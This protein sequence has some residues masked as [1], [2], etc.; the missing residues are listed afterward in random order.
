MIY[1]DGVDIIFINGILSSLPNF[2]RWGWYVGT[3]NSTYN[4]HGKIFF[5][6]FFCMLQ[7]NINVSRPA[8]PRPV[9]ACCEHPDLWPWFSC[10]P[11]SAFVGSLIPR[12]TPNIPGNQL[13]SIISALLYLATLSKVTELRWWC[14]HDLLLAPS[15]PFRIAKLYSKILWARVCCRD[16]GVIPCSGHGCGVAIHEGL[17]HD[18]KLTDLS[19][20]CQCHTLS[21]MHIANSLIPRLWWSNQ[22]E[23][24]WLF[25][26]EGTLVNLSVPPRTG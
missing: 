1:F 23:L 19:S 18:M 12:G 4:Q 9:L 15:G 8:H 3:L 16:E 10:W 20:L 2:S 17:D 11:I 25:L 6:S 24:R 22:G 26:S 13:P 21:S 14:W 5:P 7:L